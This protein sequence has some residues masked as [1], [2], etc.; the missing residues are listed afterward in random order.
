MSEAESGHRQIPLL[1]LLL[2]VKPLGH[3]FNIAPLNP[4]LLMW[5]WGLS[6]APTLVIQVYKAIRY[7]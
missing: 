7:R 4:H 2:L 5:V 1:H 3:V 6:L